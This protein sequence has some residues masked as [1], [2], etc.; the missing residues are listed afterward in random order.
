VIAAPIGD[1]FAFDIADDG[2][3]IWLKPPYSAANVAAAVAALNAF[4]GDTG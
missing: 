4:E 3:L 2:A 1:N